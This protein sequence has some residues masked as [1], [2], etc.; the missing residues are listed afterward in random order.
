MHTCC[1][2]KISDN[3]LVS[4]LKAGVAAGDQGDNGSPVAQIRNELHRR[5][6]ARVAAM[7]AWTVEYRDVR[8]GEAGAVVVKAD[9]ETAACDA[10]WRELHARP[11]GTMG[12][13]GRPRSL[14]FAKPV[15]VAS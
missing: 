14:V 13:W 8:I 6:M 15:R 12:A 7:P 2:E 1:M 4:M 9:D 10:A 11:H 5:H 3:E